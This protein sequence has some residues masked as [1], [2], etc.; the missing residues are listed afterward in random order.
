MRKNHMFLGLLVISLLGIS[1]LSYGAP[2]ADATC[3]AW[4]VNKTADRSSL[5]LSLGQQ[6]V[7]NY[8]ITVDVDVDLLD[9]NPCE[10]DEPL[11]TFDDY[12]IT[13]ENPKG[14]ID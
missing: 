11:D 1:I 4:I 6:S 3:Q 9:S 2:D 13:S 7:V 14:K 8:R 5:T 10:P 12:W